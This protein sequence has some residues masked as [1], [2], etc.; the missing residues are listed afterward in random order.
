MGR[1]LQTCPFTEW[2]DHS[3]VDQAACSRLDWQFDLQQRSSHAGDLNLRVARH[4][5]PHHQRPIRV[6]PSAVN[7]HAQPRWVAWARRCGARQISLNAR[8]SLSMALSP[9]SYA[10][11]RI[12]SKLRVPTWQFIGPER[13]S[14]SG[15]RF[16][17]KPTHPSSTSAM[18]CRSRP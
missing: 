17:Y 18:H 5:D 9:L 1:E 16:R 8:R 12:D 2:C 6:Q 14:R 11:A 13:H 3:L 4:P 10:S 7:P 15:G